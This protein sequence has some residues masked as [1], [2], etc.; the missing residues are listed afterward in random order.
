[1]RFVYGRALLKHHGR[2]RET[3]SDPG[4]YAGLSES[5]MHRTLIGQ[6]TGSVHQE[7]V[8]AELAPGGRIDAHLHAFGDPLRVARRPCRPRRTSCLL[9]V[10]LLVELA[11]GVDADADPDARSERL[12]QLAMPPAVDDSR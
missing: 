4:R 6:A 10:V 9:R 12:E 8:V 11:D 7:A 3:R 2:L 5:L 1:M